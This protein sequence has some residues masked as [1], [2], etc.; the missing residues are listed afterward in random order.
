MLI[1]HFDNDDDN[2]AFSWIHCY[3]TL[4]LIPDNV[5][6]K[7]AANENCSNFKPLKPRS[8]NAKDLS[9]NFLSF[10]QRR[11]RFNNCQK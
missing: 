11:P 8:S 10:N 4:I 1:M 9:L 5:A 7:L 6:S 3:S 2:D